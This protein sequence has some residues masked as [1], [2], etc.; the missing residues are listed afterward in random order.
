MVPFELLLLVAASSVI[1]AGGVRQIYAVEGDVNV[2]LIVN[3]CRNVSDVVPY[4][5]QTL[6]SSA[7]WTTERVNFLGILAPLKLGI[8]VYEACTEGD[9]YKTIFDLYQQDEEY[10]LGVIS[11]TNLNEKVLQFCE[12][13]EIRTAVTYRHHE[14]LMKSSIKVLSALGWN[15]NVTVLAPDKN[16]LR[17]FYRYSRREYVCVKDCL[18]YGSNCPTVLNI[19]Y[20]FVFFGTKDDIHDFLKNQNF[21]DNNEDVDG[22]FVPLEGS[23]PPDLPEKSYVILPVHSPPSSIY[24]KPENIPPTPLL[25]EVAKPLLLYVKSVEEF[26]TRNCNDTLY[27]V[28]CLRNKFNKSYYPALMTPSIIT[29]TLKVEPLRDNFVYEVFRVENNTLNLTELFKRNNLFQPFTK[30]F[31]YNIF[32]DTLTSTDQGFETNVSLREYGEKCVNYFSKRNFKIVLDSESEFLLNF[33]S[34][35]WV[36]AFLSLSLLGVLFCVS[37][38]IFLLVSIFRRDI[39]EGNPILTLALL[40]AV[41]LLF[42]SVLPFSLEYNKFTE[43]HLCIARSLAVT[44]SYATV[45]SLVLSRCILLATASKEIGFMSHIAGPVQAFLC[46]FIF[47]VQAALSLQIVGRC[48]EVFRGYSFVYLMSYNAMLLL[49]L[50][51]LCPLI[52]KCQ[53][54]YRE[55]KYFTIAT[56]LVTCVWCVWLPCYALLNDDWK[57]PILCTGLVCTAGIFLGAVFIPRTYLMTIAAAR[58]KITS[59]L[60]SLT[61]ATSAM[62]IYRSNTQPIYDCVNVAAINAVTVARAGVTTTGTPMQQPDLYSC[63]A[64]PED[65]DFDFR[66]E[67]PP[68]VDKVT[69][70]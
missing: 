65:E 53:R 32:N 37:V 69:R 62:D 51:C 21:I 49:L 30:A 7:V 45:F 23:V 16:I 14:Y 46:L 58:D 41:M 10:L 48:H 43:H 18:V 39:L 4:Q 8:G 27:K 68:S 28:N 22:L 42:C 6:M 63:P 2:A 35:A 20:P 52:Y 29:E 34:E 38:L 54:N 44:L 5:H 67:T 60:P 55:G 13:L 17:E 40:L 25:F 31:T 66:C 36:F 19:T 61:T 59:T 50:L 64:L 12:V 47:G 56:I 57:E 1:G 15:E 26:I 9:Y 70:F 33:R 24:K 3:S 11:D